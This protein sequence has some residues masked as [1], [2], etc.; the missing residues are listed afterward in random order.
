MKNWGIVHLSC[1]LVVVTAT[2]GALHAQTWNVNSNGSWDTSSNWTPNT[3]PNAQTANAT[4]G[5]IITAN[6]QVTFPRNR[7]M[8]SLTF[9]SN[10][11]YTVTRASGVGTRNMNF[12]AVGAGPAAINIA[13]GTSG[14][15]TITTVG[16]RLQ[17]NLVDTTQINHQGTGLFTIATVVTGSGGLTHTGSGTTILTGANTY[18]GV[19]TI[20]GGTLLAGNNTALGSTAAGTVVNSGGSLGLTGGITMTGEALQLAGAGN[21]GAGALFSQ[22]GNNTF[23]GNITLNAPTT[24]RSATAGQALT[25]GANAANRTLVNNGHTLTLAGPGDFFFNSQMSGAGGLTMDGT[26]TATLFYGNGTSF[27]AYSGP[28]V[29][30]AGTLIADLGSSTPPPLTPLTGPITIGGAGQAATF[31]TRWLD[32]IGNSVTVN[33][34]NQGTLR[35]RN[36]YDEA[37]FTETIAGLNLAGGALVETVNGINNPATLLLTGNIIHDGTGTTSATIAGNMIL[38][39]ATT[40]Q[41]GDSA[42]AVDLNITANILDQWWTT[43]NKTGDGTLR[44]AGN[45]TYQG[46]LTVSSGVV[47]AASDNALG[48]S[49]WNNSV[50]SGASLYLEGGINLTQGSIQIRGTGPSGEGALRATSGANTFNGTLTV[51]S[52][53]TVA[54]ASGASLAF[55]GPIDLA[56]TLTF[57]DAGNFNV[58]G[59]VYGSSA[60]VKTGSGTLQFSGSS[61]DINGLRLDALEGIV[62]LNRPGRLLNTVQGPTVGTTT[63]PAGTLRLLTGN[64][65]RNDLFVEVRESGTFDLNGFD[66][67][68]AGLRLYGGAVQ[69][70][71]GTLSIVNSGGDE[72]RTFASNQTATITGSLRSDLAQGLNITV[73]DGSPAVDL[74]ISAAISGSMASLTKDGPG[75]LQFSGNQANTYTGNTI[76]NGGVLQLNKTAG[77]N[78]I[79]GAITLN[80]GGT[81]ML[82]NADQIADS[83]GLTMAGGTFSTGTGFSESLGVLTLTSDSTINLG[84]SIHLLAFANSSSAIWSSGAVLTIN[85][86][87]G[88]EQTPGTAGRIFV[89]TNLGGLT[90]TQLS[91]I[92]FTGFAPGAILLSDGELVPVVIPEGET[93]FVVLLVLAA[94]G[95]RER[96]RLLA[97]WQKWSARSSRAVESGMPLA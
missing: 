12:D 57:A 49:A 1:F 86:W 39:G 17:V 65:I 42:A 97:S 38:Q 67:G 16:D 19:T 22:S 20:N 76:V 66:E 68:I 34:L 80:S 61:H 83:S 11:N 21:A 43:I 82:N 74:D 37:N 53:A 24:M 81:L 91:Q 55:T 36:F 14:A 10:F 71:T 40:I 8:G 25:I 87:T 54:A 33:V 94:V 63:G 28:T 45:N 72:I 70:G 64:Q 26:G 35:I 13:A 96:K 77:T 79:A 92:S 59:A 47:I 69:T 18:T 3:V 5:Q 78:A 73:A 52:P 29:V 56:N 30:N 23:D 46:P 95:W 51:A 75:T 50:L 89:G 60:L 58:S 9:D 93:V 62:E 84:D 48:A 2:A 88:Q 31:E 41:V 7:T 44:L 6:R 4:L 85:G 90:S 32:N 27:S 15:H